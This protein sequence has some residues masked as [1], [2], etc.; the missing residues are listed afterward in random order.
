[1]LPRCVDAESFSV[2]SL[3]DARAYV[4]VSNVVRVADTPLSVVWW[5]S[6]AALN[7]GLA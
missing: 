7:K 3:I 5:L 2:S 1:M 4:G 6:C